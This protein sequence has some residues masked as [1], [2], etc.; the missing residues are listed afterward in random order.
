MTR[1]ALA[2]FLL[3]ADTAQASDSSRF[4]SKV[5]S[6]FC[7]SPHGAP[8][9]DGIC[10]GYITGIGDAMMREPGMDKKLC[11]PRDLST[12]DFSK[13]VT[14]HLARHPDDISAP[15]ADIVR[16]ALLKAFACG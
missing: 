14:R 2:I 4:S 5:L 3:F 1:V 15:A 8:C 10:A 9:D 12:S 7:N 11:M 16:S 13:L 6:A